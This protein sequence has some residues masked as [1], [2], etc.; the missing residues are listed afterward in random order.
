MAGEGIQPL[1]TSELLLLV[2]LIAE[3]Q[4][5]KWKILNDLH[6][7]ALDCEGKRAGPVLVL[8]F[9]KGGWEA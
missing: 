2:I 8:H 5:W 3:N 1:F 9:M 6:K 4:F 7:A